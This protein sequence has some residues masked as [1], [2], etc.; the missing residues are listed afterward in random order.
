LKVLTPEQLARGLDERFRLL[1]GGS[2]TSLPRQQTLHALIEWS[3]ELLNQEEKELLQRL[4]VFS[5]PAA[6]A[7]ILT[8][9]STG[10]QSQG[11]LVDLLSS[12]VE[13]SLVLADLGGS[14]PR[15]HM[16]ESTRYYAIEK[17]GAEGER[18]RRRHAEHFAARMAEAAR[19]WETAATEF[20]LARHG[21]DVDNLRAALAWSFAPDGDAAIGLDLVG[22][23]HT[24]WSEFG[25]MLEHRHWVA[26]ALQH[27]DAATSAELHARV[28]SWQAGDVKDIND[29]YDADD[30]LRAASLH[31][32]AGDKFREGQMLMRAGIVQLSL[33]SGGN[34]EKLLN[35]AH[36]ILKPFGPTKSLARCL[37][38]LASARLFA[39]D[40]A[41]ARLLHAEAVKINSSLRP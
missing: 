21:G 24:L 16:L 3:Y 40:M 11:E 9:A 6:L 37:S 13:K 19:S 14:E 20:W 2:R 33:E 36:E 8:V 38:S 22:H 34:A 28:L 29:P 27:I 30:A 23:S 7:S 17:L 5:G 32:K 31:A 26:T 4:S 12:L 25:L 15:Y 10:R 35:M 39:S 1:T 18:V 41:G